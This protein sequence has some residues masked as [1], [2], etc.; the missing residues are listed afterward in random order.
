MPRRW[1]FAALLR[2]YEEEGLI[3]MLSRKKS[4]MPEKTCFNI[5][6]NRAL[7]PILYIAFRPDLPDRY[8]P[9]EEIPTW[10]LPLRCF[11][12]RISSTI[13]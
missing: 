5:L 4:P 10:D 3:G 9:I 1:T 8:T 11:A 6:N 7:L 13:T 12:I 2:Y